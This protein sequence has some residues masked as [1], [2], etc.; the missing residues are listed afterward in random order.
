MAAAGQQACVAPAVLEGCHDATRA[1][2]RPEVRRI[3]RRSVNHPSLMSPILVESVRDAPPVPA[4]LVVIVDATGV[5]VTG[6]D[7]AW[8]AVAKYA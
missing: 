5:R 3:G 8:R 6:A 1:D 7:E 2:A 4:R